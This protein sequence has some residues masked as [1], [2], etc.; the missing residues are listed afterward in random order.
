MATDENM[1]A[2]AFLRALPIGEVF[3]HASTN[4]QPD[5]WIKIGPDTYR[6]TYHW[7][8]FL[9]EDFESWTHVELT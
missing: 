1:D 7:I 4:Q 9:A 8:R 2:P 3:T 6:R 5:S